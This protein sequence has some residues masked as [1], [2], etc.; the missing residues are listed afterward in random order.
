VL[1]H[2]RE[3]VGRGTLELDHFEILTSVVL[4]AASTADLADVMARVPPVVAMTPGARRLSQPLELRTYTGNLRMEGRWQVGKVTNA[5]VA[6]G[7]M[8]LDLTDAELDDREIDLTVKVATG[9]A[10]L[11]IPY[12]IEVQLV[13]VAGTVKNRLGTSIAPPGAPL[14]RLHLTSATGTIRLRRPEVGKRSWWRRRLR[15]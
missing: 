6:T 15:R 2:L 11:I 10:T 1:L 4:G 7:G 14:L 9:S 12:G 13:R 3:L 5:T 8:L